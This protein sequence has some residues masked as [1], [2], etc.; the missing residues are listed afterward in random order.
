MN[1]NMLYQIKEYFRKKSL[2]K[3]LFAL[4]KLNHVFF[5]PYLKTD[6]L[7][8]EVYYA[9]IFYRKRTLF[10]KTMQRA[11]AKNQNHPDIIAKIEHM[12][13]IIFSLHLLRFRIHD[14][15]TF[16][17]CR[18]ELYTIQQVST[19]LINTLGKS[20]SHHTL[21]SIDHL[22]A[23]V[24]ALE[25]IY[26]QTLKILIPDPS[27]FLFFIQDLYALG[28]EIENTSNLIWHPAHLKLTKKG[29]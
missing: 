7:R 23:S 17:I 16:E 22:L 12:Y 25:S 29:K 6:F 18:R 3:A 19:H 9:K 24:H 14:Y 5:S 4:A 21:I 11:R 15:A 20:L 10:F 1:F 8:R 28:E 2:A 26:H 13:E 27:A